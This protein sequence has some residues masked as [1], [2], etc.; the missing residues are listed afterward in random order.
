M[1]V[2]IVRKTDIGLL[3]LTYFGPP[4][5]IEAIRRDP[6]LLGIPNGLKA[7]YASVE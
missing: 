1:T 6:E 4:I 7:F 5:D 3:S 2:T